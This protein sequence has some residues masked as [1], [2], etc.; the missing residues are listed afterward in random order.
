MRDV[1]I[2]NKGKY[3]D[4]DLPLSFLNLGC[5]VTFKLTK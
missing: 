4:F 5:K 3:R 1:I 2:L